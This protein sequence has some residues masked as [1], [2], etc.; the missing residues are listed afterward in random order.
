MFVQ[1]P[2]G[3]NTTSWMGRFW[4]NRINAGILDS[5]NSVNAAKLNIY[6]NTEI[7]IVDPKGNILLPRSP[8]YNP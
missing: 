8:I 6:K 1:V 2:E 4:G 7:I 3:T 5:S